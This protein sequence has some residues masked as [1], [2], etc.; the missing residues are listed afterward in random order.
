MEILI[1]ASAEEVVELIIGIQNGSQEGI[2]YTSE[3]E[4]KEE[5]VGEL[6]SRAMRNSLKMTIQEQEEGGL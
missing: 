4:S 3:L 2:D 5:T 1:K 6:F